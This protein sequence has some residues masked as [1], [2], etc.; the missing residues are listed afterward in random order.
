MNRETVYERSE[1]SVWTLEVNV[2][3]EPHKDEK[4][5]IG[6]P[7]CCHNRDGIKVMVNPNK[8]TI[9]KHA[10]HVGYESPVIRGH[11]EKN[12]E[13]LL[14]SHAVADKTSKKLK[15]CTCQQG[16]GETN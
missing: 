2:F 5:A 15:I 14:V 12:D 9:V 7:D 4:D 3:T 8:W 6:Q 16:V 1:R 13:E 11:I 10:V